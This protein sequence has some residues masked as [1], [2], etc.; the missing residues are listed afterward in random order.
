MPDTTSVLSLPL[1]QA[2]QAQKHVPHNEALRVLDA[3]V[4][5]SVADRTLTTPP[6]SP[7]E[8]DRHLVASG[9]I[10]AWAG[11]TG[12]IAV[13]EAGLWAFYQPQP[14]WRAWVEAENALIVWSGAAWTGI[15]GAQLSIDR[16]G[17]SATP[18]PTNRLSVA[19]PAVL[20][21]HAGTG[22]EVTIN[23]AAAAND[24]AIAFKD[25]FSTRGLIGLLGDDNL[26]LK[27]SP[28]GTTFH[29]GLTIL[30]ATGKV[31]ADRALNLNPAAADLASP[32]DGD[33]WYNSTTGKFRGRQG[34]A[35]VDLIAA[36]GG[37]SFSDTVFEITDGADA[38]KV[39]KFELSGLP[40][41]TTR[42][43]TLP[44]A[45]ATLAH[46]GAT[47]Q[48]FAGH[49]TLGAN[50]LDLGL[51]TAAA[52]YNLGTGATLAATTKAVNIGTGGLASS[53][54]NVTIG[55]AVVG[56][57]GSMVVHSPSVT[58]ASS[59]SAI[60][61]ASANV[62]AQYLGLGGATADATNRLSVN[63]PAVLLNHAGSSIDMTFNKNA[64][65]NDATMSFK[66]GFSTRA[67]LG[68]AGSDNLTLKVSPDG[69][70]YFD[71]FTIAAATGRV[72]IANGAVLNPA[73]ADLASPVDGAIWYNSTTG[74]FRGRQAGSSV[75]L[76]GT[77][78]VSDGSK[79]DITVSGSGT[80]WQVSPDIR[81][82]LAIA[83][84]T[85]SFL[86]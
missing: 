23:K 4:Q 54:T 69:T 17:V 26:T 2:A 83:M 5:L 21:N 8:G 50:T 29:N 80:V 47:A 45:T 44:N 19:S 28:D 42:T 72:T 63:S 20:L 76:I 79:G 71:G 61:M 9:A 49:L 48:T 38:T 58:F 18:D 84:N 67:I 32:V 86:N 64:P 57:L 14:G 35:S 13:Y 70:S 66:T 40:T 7:S 81:Y 85:N 37:A 77:G 10:G 53:T 27:V 6:G 73:A 52:T 16:L 75:D 1:I 55:S 74:K 59:V 36:G 41:A 12:R 56:A 33:V 34:G 43:F 60:A 15:L 24:A 22:S 78:G 68:L 51:G 31:R 82:G 62:S 11:Q 39:A 65:A 3:I 30:G 25:A 46:L